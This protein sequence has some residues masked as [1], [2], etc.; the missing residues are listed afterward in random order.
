MEEKNSMRSASKIF[1]IQYNTMK[2]WVKRFKE[3]GEFSP[4]PILGKQP[5]KINLATLKKQV[6][7]H[8]DWFQ[9]EHAQTF[10][11]TQSA[12]T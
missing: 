4:K 10:D 11:V 12:I 8:P 5:T 7:E 9:H 3:T 2:E 1:D 6:L